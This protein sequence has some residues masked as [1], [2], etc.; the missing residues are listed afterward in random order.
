MNNIVS[1]IRSSNL[2]FTFES[3]CIVKIPLYSDDNYRSI[4]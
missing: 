4:C 1:N 2:H 3:Y